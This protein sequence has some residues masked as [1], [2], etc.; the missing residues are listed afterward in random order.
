[1]DTATLS[2]DGRS[3]TVHVALVLCKRGGRKLVIAPEGASWAPPRPQVDKAMVKALARAFRWRR[4][5]ETGRHSTV[6]DLAAAEKINASYVS[7][8]LRLTLLAPEIVEQIVDGRQPALL[9]IEN[10][11][12]PVSLEW[13]Q[14]HAAILATLPLKGDSN[15]C[16]QESSILAHSAIAGF[17]TGLEY[18]KGLPLSHFVERQPPSS[19]R[20]DTP[21]C[22]N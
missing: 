15:A 13:G 4:L 17:R 2:S 14:Q 19:S 12:R 10:L 3:L 8:V 20:C 21:R 18:L 5:L 6:S 16:P 11:L 9:K 1:M 7:R 22:P